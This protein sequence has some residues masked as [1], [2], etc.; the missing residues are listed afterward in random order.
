MVSLAVH[1]ALNNAVPQYETYVLD[2]SEVDFKDI[3]KKDIHSIAHA[4]I[5]QA[6]HDAMVALVPASAANAGALLTSS[7]AG[8]SDSEL[9]A[10]GIQ[11]GKEAA[12]SVLAERQND[13]PL[14]FSAYP[15]GTE[16]GEYRSTPPYTVARPP[17]WP[18]NAVYA[19]NM[20]T[21]NPFG[22]EASDQFRAQPP[23]EINSPEYT[24]DYNEVK[25]LGGEISLERTQEQKD[26][27]IFFLDNVSGSMNR[28][29][30]L[31]LSRRSWTDGRQHDYLL[32]P[33]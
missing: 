19:P 22:I 2:N 13:P 10:R 8:I 24:A 32:L 29:A 26:L 17:V 30:E 12:L 25:R 27:G 11:I 18:A 33:I 7:L 6:A 5:A 9:K 1:D 14:G 23:Y 31:W 21:F 16:P 3:S 15:Q 20:G 28:V 4:A